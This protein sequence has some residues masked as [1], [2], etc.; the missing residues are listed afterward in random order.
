MSGPGVVLVAVVGAVIVALWAALGRQWRLRSAPPEV[1][2]ALRALRGR[3]V[4]AI[5]LAAAV[6]LGAMLL[7]DRNQSWQGLSLAVG[8]GLA[9][10]TG[11]LAF[12]AI[13]AT[14][15][16]PGRYAATL[17]V[18]TPLTYVST[19][20]ALGLLVPAA[21][22]TALLLATGLTG[23][24]DSS[25]RER[26]VTI[27][28]GATSATASPYPGW[29]YAAPMLVV[30]AFIL[31]TT[32]AALW[33]VSATAALP[34]S[35]WERED[36][37]WRVALV[38][39]VGCLGSAALLA[40]LAGIAY[41]AGSGLRSISTASGD[42]RAALL[43]AAACLLVA[44]IGSFVIAVVRAAAALTRAVRLPADVLGAPAPMPPSSRSRA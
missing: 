30:T 1:V 24:A 36:R 2:A 27:S 38:R 10:G 40:Q 34:A 15:S 12:A 21:L 28:H 3:A 13:G 19:R 20:S 22:S 41:F 4:A 18:R 7:A 6:Q 42:R 29:F 35:G 9:A 32:V 25:G 11:L 33:R 5:A 37:R 39:V 23:S 31:L 14:T 17:D 26:A 43:V 16:A 44:G 8:P